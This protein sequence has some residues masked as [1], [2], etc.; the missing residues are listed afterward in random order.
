M[1]LD[2]HGADVVE[3]RQ[4]RAQQRARRGH[5]QSRAQ[6]V[7]R[8]VADD[9]SDPVAAQS[10]V[11]E[12][13]AARL[14]ARAVEPGDLHA[15]AAHRDAR[16]HRLL[17]DLGLGEFGLHATLLFLHT[18]ETRTLDELGTLCGQRLDQL[19]ILAAE[20]L[21]A[22]PTVRIE[23][24]QRPLADANRRAD[25]LAQPQVDHRL[26]I[27]VG[28]ISRVE[29]R[30]GAAAVEDAL[31]DGGGEAKLDCLSITGAGGPDRQ[32][33]VGAA[34][35]NQSSVRPGQGQR[36][37]DERI[38][39]AGGERPVEHGHLARGPRAGPDAGQQLAE[40]ERLGHEIIRTQAQALHAV[41]LGIPRG[42]QDDRR[43]VTGLAECFEHLEAAL[44]RK[45]QVEQDQVEPLRLGPFD[46]CNAIR[47]VLHGVAFRPQ[48]ELKPSGHAA[49]VF[50]EQDASHVLH[51]YRRISRMKCASRNCHFFEKRA[52]GFLTN[53][54]AVPSVFL[55]E[56]TS[57]RP[58]RWGLRAGSICTTPCPPP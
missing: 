54:A 40:S 18:L 58:R 2:E 11:V 41:R 23:D 49:I 57:S 12:V 50:N 16:E 26:A 4:E 51:M 43:Q 35:E 48:I 53:G 6:P 17:H 25:R 39:V 5:E 24:A 42:H 19:E 36:P 37:V 28:R 46:A 47:G 29:H 14:V 9:E 7:A 44:Q 45:H 52:D 13:V 38:E 1:K 21:G 55:R 15:R 30:L 34:Q 27:P 10:Q 56:A 31:D 22:G 33:S 8:D 20:S 32:L 3:P